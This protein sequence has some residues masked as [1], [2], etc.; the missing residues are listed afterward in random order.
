[1][2][3]R[4]PRLAAILVAVCILALILWYNGSGQSPTTQSAVVVISPAAHP[5]TGPAGANATFVL[6]DE[7]AVLQTQNPF[8]PKGSVSRA[9]GTESSL[10]F[11]G[12]A[13]DGSLLTALIEDVAVKQVTRGVVGDKLAR[14]RITAIDLDGLVY[15]AGGNSRRILV[16]QNLEGTVVPPT[17]PP[18]PPPPPQAAQPPAG[19][20]QQGPGGPAGPGGMPGQQ[21]GQGAPPRNRGPAEG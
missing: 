6:P 11:R 13:R 2:N 19:P 10:V 3:W 12:A 9:P 15:A 18:P 20:D 14:G 7:F 16:G 1:M 4:N 8:S 21:G 17:P 5:A